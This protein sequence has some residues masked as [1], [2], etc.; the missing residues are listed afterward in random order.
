LAVEDLYFDIFAAGY[1]NLDAVLGKFLPSA[2]FPE[3][4]IHLNALAHKK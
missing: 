3:D 4:E 1:T 2:W